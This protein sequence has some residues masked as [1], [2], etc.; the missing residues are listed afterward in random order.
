MTS[1]ITVDGVSKSIGGTLLYSD[2][3][4]ELRRGGLYALRGPNGSGKSV[5]LR[6]LCGFLRPDSGSI[7]IDPSISPE[8]RTFP[9]GFGITIDGPAYIAGLSA[10][11]NLLRLAAIRR[12]IGLEEIRATLASVGLAGTGRAAVRSFSSGMKQ[13]LS[14][15]QALMEDPKVLLLDEPFTALDTE[16]VEMVKDLLRRRAAAGVTVLLAVHGEEDL[17]A[18]CDAVLTIDDHTLSTT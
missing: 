18:E 16:S 6:L 4:F 10:E 7:R 12:R 17:L 13:K 2:V 3:S 11:Q 9:D 5:L 14:L 15:A 1:A 8:G